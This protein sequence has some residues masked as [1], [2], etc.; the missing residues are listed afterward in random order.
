[1]KTILEFEGE[2]FVMTHP[3]QVC[4]KEIESGVQCL[5]HTPQQDVMDALDRL[6]GQPMNREDKVKLIREIGKAAMRMADGLERTY[7]IPA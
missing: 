6:L 5:R 3:C 1:M 7:T 4:G 2:R